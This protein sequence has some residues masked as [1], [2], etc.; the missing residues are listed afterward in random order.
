MFGP[1]AQL[2]QNKQTSVFLEP[3]LYAVCRIQLLS[4]VLNVLRV[5]MHLHDEPMQR[6]MG[7]DIFIM[8]LE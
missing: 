3:F 1:R 5:V 7:V 6:A 4:L 8:E 2:S